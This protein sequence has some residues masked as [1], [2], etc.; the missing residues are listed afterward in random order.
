MRMF[1][2]KTEVESWLISIPAE[3]A[4]SFLVYIWRRL[5]PSWFREHGPLFENLGEGLQWFTEFSADAE[6]QIV[7]CANSAYEELPSD[8]K[9]KYR[10]GF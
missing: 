8:F 6:D 3:E 5:A 10:N 9:M 7:Y 1:N 4:L 2:C